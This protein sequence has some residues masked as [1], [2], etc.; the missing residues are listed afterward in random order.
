M[1]G[2]IANS[3]ERTMHPKEGTYLLVNSLFYLGAR[4]SLKPQILD[5]INSLTVIL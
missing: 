2:V 3:K 1:L 5:F 4:T